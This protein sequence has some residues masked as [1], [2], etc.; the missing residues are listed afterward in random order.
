MQGDGSGTS[1]GAIVG[2][3]LGGLIGLAL[4]GENAIQHLIAAS[5]LISVLRFVLRLAIHPSSHAEIRT[6][7]HY[8]MA[9]A[10]ALIA[11]LPCMHEHDFDRF[12]ALEVLRADQC[13]L[14]GKSQNSD[15]QTDH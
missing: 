3:T 5:S 1:V 7:H 14:V 8:L 12:L 10:R 6:F 15:M 13:V 9:I 4:I 11:P 2:G